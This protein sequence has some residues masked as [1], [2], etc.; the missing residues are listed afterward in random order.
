MTIA[1]LVEGLAIK[2]ASGSASTIITDI[3]EDS[4]RATP[5]CLFAARAGLS[6]DGRAFI[7]D[8]VARGAVAVL[9]TETD[10][11]RVPQSA[12]ALLAAD[13]TAV[14]GALA[15]RLNGRPS[16][17]LRLVGVTGTNGK[18]TVS[19]LA[20][21]ML[22][23]AGVRCGLMGT[24][25]I[26]DGLEVK[27]ADLTTPPA[28]EISR[29]LAAMV[30][31]G[32][33]AAVMEVSS[34]ALHQGRTAGLEFD[35]AV[36]TNLSGEHLDYHGTLE[37]Y[38]RAK[39]ILLRSLPPEGFAVINADDPTAGRMTEGCDA[40]V[41]SCSLSDPG[42]DCYAEIGRQ[43]L[44]SVEAVLRGPWGAFEVSLPL[45][46]RHNVA[47]ALQAVAACFVLGV[48]AAALGRA[49]ACC[50]APPGRL[51]PVTGPDDAFTILVDYA[52][53]DDALAN[54]LG[55]LRPLVPEGGSLRVVF[56]CGGDR[57][58][59]K[60]PR[61]GRVAA[62]FADELYVTSD[63]PR[64]EDPEVIID[65]IVKGVPS[66]RWPDTIMLVDRR[67]AI[68]TAVDRAR[69]GDV[70]LIAGKGHEPYQIVGTEKRT[71]DDRHV[72]AEALAR[73]RAPATA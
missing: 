71:F 61:M 6:F 66:L 36:F 12:A 34:H 64:T 62:E 68:E 2:L 1:E 47:N 10:R 49:L 50:T 41:V 28:P 13:V 56:G 7:G 4:R 15:E 21:Q 60:R 73:H 35:V 14:V 23:R 8:A 25:R 33:A 43:S 45:A 72:A 59:T 26:D 16:R 29:Q 5:G 31:N 17:A 44:G 51:E 53:T 69:P 30:R 27:P 48:D 42:A 37:A 3:V 19:H 11:Q 63:N 52:H 57:D 58:P 9:T 54:V 20:H 24:V 22:Q 70:V 32:C 65:Q 40:R 46:G 18:T 67:V 39:A 55:T 38:A